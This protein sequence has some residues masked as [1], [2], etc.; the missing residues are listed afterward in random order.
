[1]QDAEKADVRAPML[2]VG[3]NLKQCGRT[4]LEQESK[5]DLLVLPDQRDQS[6]WNAEDQVIVADRQQFALTGAKPL[7]SGI[8]LTLGAVT[9]AAGE[10]PVS[11]THLRAHE[12]GR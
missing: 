2:R 1:M 3:G 6:M 7:L 5:E 4:G 12:T 8:G 10:I 9:I 11:Y